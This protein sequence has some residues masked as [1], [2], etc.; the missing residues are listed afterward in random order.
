MPKGYPISQL[1]YKHFK[2]TTDKTVFEIGAF[3]GRFLYHFGKLG[4]T[5]H[6]IDQTPYLTDME[7]WFNKENFSIGSFVGGDILKLGFEKTY[8]VVFSSGFFEHFENFEEIIRIHANLT[9][10]GGHVFITAPNFSG[11]IQKYLHTRLDKENTDRHNLHAMDAEKW[12][13]VLEQEGF[14]MVEAGYFGGFDFWVDREKRNIFKKIITKLI[15]TLTPMRFLPN[16]RS[17]SPEII[18]IAKKK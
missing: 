2:K 11:N 9:K 6:G 8:D 5:L 4:Y 18:L 10:S 15:T 12:K 17:Y 1:L 7:K 16:S 3:P 13:K 14:E